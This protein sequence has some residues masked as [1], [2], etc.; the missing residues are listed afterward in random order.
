MGSDP[1]FAAL[2]RTLS[3]H[4]VEY[5]LVGGMAAILEGGVWWHPE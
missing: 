4:E 5:I 2:L 1:R 3:V